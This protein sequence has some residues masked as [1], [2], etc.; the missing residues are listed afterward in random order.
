MSRLT[1]GSVHKN[2]VK[3]KTAKRNDWLRDRRD[4]EKY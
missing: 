3:V 2:Q 1:T 4:T